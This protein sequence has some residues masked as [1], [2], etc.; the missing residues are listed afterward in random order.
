MTEPAR[1]AKLNTLDGTD[2]LPNRYDRVWWQEATTGP[3]RVVAAVS[4]DQIETALDL[5]ACASEPFLLLWVLDTPRGGSQR[6]RYQSPPVPLEEMRRVLRQY[7]NLFEQDGRS[8]LWIHSREPLATIVLDRHDLLYLYG[9]PDAFI[10]LLRSKGFE[11]AQAKIPAPHAHEYHA[12]F[13]DL[14]RAFALEY[15]WDVSDLR[16]EDD[17]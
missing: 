9:P 12:A 11:N 4:E 15:D 16:P 3:S 13:D 7:R 2:W 5:A 8:D 10:S 17:A 14:E 6:G 1:P